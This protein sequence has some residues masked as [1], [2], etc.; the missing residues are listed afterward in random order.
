MKPIDIPQNIRLL[1]GQAGMTQAELGE[2]IGMAQ[3]QIQKIETGGQSLKIDVLQKIASALCVDLSEIIFKAHPFPYRHIPIKGSV[4]TGERMIVF[5][6]ANDYLM[7]YET[8]AFDTD[9]SDLLAMK[10]QGDSMN[11]MVPNGAVII[12]DP[13][14]NDS[15]M[16]HKQAVVAIQD[17]EW[18]FKIWDKNAGVFLPNSTNNND[19]PLIV[20]K[21]NMII[22]GKVIAFV[23]WC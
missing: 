7:N 4:N 2:K 13:K 21:Y 20:A 12:I 5:D 18:I 23:A 9:R 6:D 11:L 16:L 22:L 14:Q 3:G 1:R 17:S 8:V 15:Q 19:Y 10:A